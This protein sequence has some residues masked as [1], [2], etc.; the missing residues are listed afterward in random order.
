MG[1]EE[2]ESIADN[3]ALAEAE[4]EERRR[5]LLR[6][7]RLA[8]HIGLWGFLVAVVIELLVRDTDLGKI[9]TTVGPLIY[10]TGPVILLPIALVFLLGMRKLI[11]RKPFPDW[12]HAAAWTLF[13]LSALCMTLYITL[14]P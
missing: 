7:W 11:F 2:S 9:I 13:W 14:L 10:Y 8:A 5:K 1:I 12:G 3:A 4:L 6:P